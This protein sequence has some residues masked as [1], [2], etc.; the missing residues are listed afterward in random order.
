MRIEKANTM[1]FGESMWKGTE[2]W[3]GWRKL[4][5]REANRRERR[6]GKRIPME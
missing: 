6:A 5:K 3:P 1:R 2:R 4:A